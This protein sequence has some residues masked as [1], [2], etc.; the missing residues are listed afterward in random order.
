MDSFIFKK[1]VRFVLRNAFEQ[2]C[3]ACSSVFV[4]SEPL[5]QNCMQKWE[6]ENQSTLKKVSLTELPQD[7][8]WF[9][10]TLYYLHSYD[11]MARTLFQLAKFHQDSSAFQLLS[12]SFPQNFTLSEN[13]LLIPLP[14]SQKVVSKFARLLEAKSPGMLQKKIL[15]KQSSIFSKPI[16]SLNRSSRYRTILGQFQLIGKNSSKIN[17][18]QIFLIDDLFTTGATANEAARTI[19][20]SGFATPENISVFTLMR[21]REENFSKAA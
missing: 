19:V 8:T 3:P 16:K 9:F 11:S 20:E 21:G 17:N 7:R 4:A 1:H 10:T 6:V 14:S 12:H 2:I 18:R 5:C 15:R 13:A